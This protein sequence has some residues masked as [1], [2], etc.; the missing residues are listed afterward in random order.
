M[1][2]ELGGGRCKTSNSTAERLPGRWVLPG[3][4]A[5]PLTRC[6]GSGPMGTPGEL[7][8]PRGWA[9]ATVK[10]LVMAVLPTGASLAVQKV[11]GILVGLRWPHSQA[12]HGHTSQRMSSS[13]KGVPS[14]E[15]MWKS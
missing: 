4:A 9:K 5:Q 10:A 7:P 1:Q 6:H 13:Y 11:L 3:S 2:R 8:E 14:T 15:Q 12:W